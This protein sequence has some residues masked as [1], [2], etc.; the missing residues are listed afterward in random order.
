MKRIAAVVVTAVLVIIALSGG[1]RQDMAVFN[2]ELNYYDGEFSLNINTGLKGTFIQWWLVKEWDDAVWRKEFEALT[3]LGMEYVVLTPVAILERPDDTYRIYTVYPTEI[4]GFETIKNQRGQLYP[5]VV[6][7]CL[8]N[9]EDLG[10]KVFFGLNFSEDWWKKRGNEEWIL[11]RVREGNMLATELWNKY[12][13]RYP[14]AFYGWY[15]TWEVDNFHF[16][17]VL[18]I[19]KSKE[20][21]SRAIKLHLDYLVENNIRLPFMVAP[22]MDARLGTPGGYARL[23]EYIFKNA[24]FSEGDIF[25][26]QDSVC[27]GG[28]KEENMPKWFAAMKNAVNTV[29]GMRFWADVETFDMKDWTAI[30]L[31]VFLRRMNMLD[32]IV[33]GYMTFSYTHYYSPNVT[34]EG[35]HRTLTDFMR[36]GTLE[37]IPPTTPDKFVAEYSDKGARLAWE[38]GYDNIGIFGY[39]LYRDGNLITVL[40]EG[41]EG[42]ASSKRGVAKEYIDTG[43]LEGHEYVYELSCFDFAGNISEKAKVILKVSAYE[44]GLE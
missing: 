29:P 10:I 44:N 40:K 11:E 26:L 2:V 4:E 19:G 20:I 14:N 39:L 24:G 7:R 38:P 30:G 17:T 21:L 9:A 31:D 28:V 6:D 34:A 8:R 22:F 43:V 25:C 32:G 13:D 1:S 33:D 5:D 3:E 23:W 15:W 18:D 35:F 42:S 12:R 37:K 27:A 41:T 16:R 36:S